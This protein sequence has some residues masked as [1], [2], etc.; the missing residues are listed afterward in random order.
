[1]VTG[2]Q[3]PFVG[4]T[5]STSGTKSERIQY[6][7]LYEPPP[8]PRERNPALAVEVEEVFLKAMAKSPAARYPSVMTL[9]DAVETAYRAPVSPEP[10]H[11]ETPE[12]VPSLAMLIARQGEYTGHTFHIQQGVC[13]IGRS[14]Y[15]DV[16][17][18]QTNVSR[19]HAVI[20]WARGYF[21]LQD[22]QSLHGTYLNGQRIQAQRLT[23]GDLIYIGD[24]VFEFRVG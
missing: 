17:L 9:L 10:R 3:V 2:G 8:P 5:K 7:H 11:S 24:T 20:R 1:M 6:Q 19:R 22:E 4:D 13:R 23:D 14:R 21:W 12:I 15:N 18:N 16:R